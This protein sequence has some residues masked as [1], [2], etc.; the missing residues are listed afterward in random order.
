MMADIFA[1]DILKWIFVMENVWHHIK[2]LLTLSE[3]KQVS[4]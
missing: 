2:I 3:Y 1:N 4:L